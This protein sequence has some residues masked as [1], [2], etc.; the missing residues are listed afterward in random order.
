MIQPSLRDLSGRH[1]EPGVETP[2]YSHVSLRE[3]PGGER[4]PWREGWKSFSQVAALIVAYCVTRVL[5]RS[6][7]SIAC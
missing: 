1:P 7:L 2:G 3:N 6:H 5:S 4:K